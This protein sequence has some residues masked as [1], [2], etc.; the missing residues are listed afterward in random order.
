M[1][2][3]LDNTLSSKRMLG[4]KGGSML[5]IQLLIVEMLVVA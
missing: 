2:A 3:G 5:R 1:K 4:C